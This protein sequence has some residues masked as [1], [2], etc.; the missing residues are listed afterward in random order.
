MASLVPEM[1]EVAPASA[2]PDLEVE[3]QVVFVCPPL[4]L[5]LVLVST[6]FSAT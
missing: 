2:A 6:S 3:R 5:P 1:T 4:S